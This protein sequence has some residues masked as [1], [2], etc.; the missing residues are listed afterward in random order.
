LLAEGVKLVD[1]RRPLEWSKTGVVEGSTLLT[2]HR[3]NGRLMDRFQENITEIAKPDE[4]LALICRSGNRS[5]RV[6]MWLAEKEGYTQVYNVT[7]G[8]T[9]WKKAGNATVPPTLD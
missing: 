1:L 5:R 6:A 9:G 8:V 4:K 3:S 2:S 7:G